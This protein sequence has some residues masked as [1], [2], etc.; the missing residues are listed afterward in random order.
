MNKFLFLFLILI[1]GLILP[2]FYYYISPFFMREGFSK[3]NSSLGNIEGDYPYSVENVLLQGDYPVNFDNTTSTN[4]ESTMWKQKPVYNVGSFAQ[5]T[6]NQRYHKNPDNGS[7][8]PAD[9]CDALYTN[10]NVQTNIVNQLPAVEPSFNARVNY[11][12]SDN[13]LLAFRSDTSSI[14]Y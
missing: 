5:L 12:N 13:N 14:L 4:I 7:C 2:A 3:Y 8:T 10:K 1:I 9:I 11:Y 6:N